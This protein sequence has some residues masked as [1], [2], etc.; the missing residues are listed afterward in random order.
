MIEYVNTLSDPTLDEESGKQIIKEFAKKYTY[1]GIIKKA[2]QK[3]K[4]DLL[5][6]WIISKGKR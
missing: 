5:V 6:C 4:T 3:R 2:E 1:F